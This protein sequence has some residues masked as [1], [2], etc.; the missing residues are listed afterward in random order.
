MSVIGDTSRIATR[1]QDPFGVSMALG[2]TARYRW[3]AGDH[4]GALAASEEAMTIRHRLG[5]VTWFADA[6]RF[7]AYLLAELGEAEIAAILLAASERHP[8]SQQ[9]EVAEKER[10]KEA[11]RDR[12]G[13]TEFRRA[14]ERGLAVDLDEAYEIAN[15][16]FTFCL[17]S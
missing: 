4:E 14:W 16:L 10:A 11:V 9:D 5:L 13:S 6:I 15:K 17:R 2:L 3:K 8:P 7:H 1:L 12:L